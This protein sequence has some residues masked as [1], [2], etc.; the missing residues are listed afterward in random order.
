MPR[1]AL[2]IQ[3]SA[4]GAASDKLAPVTGTGIAAAAVQRHKP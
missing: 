4:D 2:G 1:L 3:P